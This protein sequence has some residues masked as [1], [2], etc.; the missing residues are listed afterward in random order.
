MDIIKSDSQSNAQIKANIEAYLRSLGNWE[1]IQDNMPASNITLIVDLLAGFASFMNYRHKMEREETYLQKAKQESSVY[2]ISS[3]FGYSLNRFSSPVIKLVYTEVDTI[4]LESGMVLGHYGDRPLY[5]F[6]EP[7]LIEKLDVIDVHLGEYFEHETQ[8]SYVN[9][10]L[11]IE[12]FPQVLEAIDR[13][14]VRVEINDVATKTSRDIEDYV[15]FG[16]VIDFSPTPRDSKI[17]LADRA[18]S[19]G[20]TIGEGDKIVVKY[21]ETAGYE[22]ELF[23]TEVKPIEGYQVSEIASHGGSGDSIEKIRRLAPLLFSTLRRMVTARDHKYITEAHPLIRS[24]YAERD[25][26]QPLITRVDFLAPYAQEYQIQITSSV[27]TIEGQWNDTEE[28]IRNKFAELINH[29]LVEI[30]N[31]AGGFLIIQNDA[32][33][34]DLV[35]TATDNVVLSVLEEREKPHCCTVEI[36][37]VKHDTVDQ[38]K[39]LTA[40]EQADLSTYFQDYKMVGLSIVLRAAK[41]EFYRF[42][43]DIKLSDVKYEQL[44]RDGIKEVLSKYELTLN[45]GFSYG[46]ALAQIAQIST[47]EDNQEIRPILSVVPKQEVYDVEPQKSR[48]L[49]FNDVDLTIS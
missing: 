41:A 10:E 33:D 13:N 36:H 14:N 37:Y 24:A 1:E 20:Q 44:V 30:V 46:E 8:A 26:G 4:R 22:E 6:G 11:I 5:Y 23:L 49:H 17:F 3:T 15:V 35:I 19:Y 40:F 21:M 18:Y 48:Y 45:T 28:T 9:D 32:R 7:K 43:V 47:I 27:Y 38:P 2:E 12:L 39:L 34:N 25:Q 29:P 31:T 16:N 42:A